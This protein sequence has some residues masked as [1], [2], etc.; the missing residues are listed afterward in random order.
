VLPTNRELSRVAIRIAN[1]QHGTVLSPP[2]LTN[3]QGFNDFPAVR[4]SN[5]TDGQKKPL[6]TD[7]FRPP[8]RLYTVKALKAL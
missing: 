4:A 3:N 2:S 6:S 5:P 8:P 1:Q 7:E